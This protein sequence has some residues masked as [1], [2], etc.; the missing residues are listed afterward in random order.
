MGGHVALTVDFEFFSDTFA[1]QKLG[2]EWVYGEDGEGGVKRLLELFDRYQV[3]STFFVVARHA[4]PYRELLHDI[5]RRGHEIAS[6]TVVHSRFDGMGK[7]IAREVVDS[8]RMLEDELGAEVRGFRSPAFRID[9][10]VVEALERAGYSYDSS[11]VPCWHIPGWYGFPKAPVH[12]FK[13]SELFPMADSALME[14]PVAVSPCI[15]LPVSG[16]WMRLFGL[17]Y[18]MRGIRSSLK[19]GL[20]PVLY[21]HPWEVVELPRLK[22]IPWRVYYRTGQK[23]FAMIEHMVKNVN[24]AFVPIRDLLPKGVSG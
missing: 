4:R 10:A 5:Q 17:G 21:V 22:G 24:A 1:F 7:D 15:R 12:P 9:S 14:F 8:K 18:T 19:A 16:A 13:I 20:D 2:T 3:K 23:A 6:H 11:V